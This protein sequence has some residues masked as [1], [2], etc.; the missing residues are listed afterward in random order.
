MASEQVSGSELTQERHSGGNTTQASE[1][2]TPG[3]SDVERQGQQPGSRAIAGSGQSN[4]SLQQGPRG[5][6]RS[7]A[8]EGFGP[9]SLMRRFS[10][11]MDRLFEG[12]FG[13]GSWTSDPLGAIGQST[14]WPQLEVHQE[15]GRWVVQADVPGLRREDVNVE[16]RDGE[17]LISGE[18]RNQSETNERGFYRSE[19]TYGAF[20]RAIPLP[21][22]ANIES[23]S[24]SFDNGVLRIE[25][26][27]PEQAQRS[28]RI[29]VREGSTQ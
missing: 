23:A 7:R 6:S 19:R 14:R 26:E 2:G 11:D 28:R 27:V 5:P 16:V 29:E 15:G 22:G 9:F 3:A 10:E 1:S 8:S 24:A 12:F 21:E 25:L 18:R 4:R 13:P 20:S 17:L